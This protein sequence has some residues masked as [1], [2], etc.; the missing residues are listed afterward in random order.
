VIWIESRRLLFVHN[1]KCAGTA[2]HNALL[3]QFPDAAVSWGRRYDVLTDNIQDMAHL[4]PREAILHFALKQPFRSFGIIRDPYARFMS[5]YYH[6]K[7]WNP[8]HESLT[9][10][11]LAFD[12][13]DEAR[14]RTD[15]KFVHFAPQYRFFLEG[16][17]RVVTHVFRYEDLPKAWPEVKREFSLDKDLCVENRLAERF[18]EPMSDRLVARINFLY[19]RDFALFGYVPQRVR[20]QPARGREYYSRYARLWPE[21]RGLDISDAADT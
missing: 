17:R 13:L 14:I 20:R 4:T 12:V 2:I 16:R 15:W 7:H 11:E 21:R 10:E 19:A 8:A 6:F 18:I 1:P 9:P 5:S 3:K